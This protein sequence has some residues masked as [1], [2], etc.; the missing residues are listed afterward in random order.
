[1][2]SSSQPARREG[3]NYSESS[4][5]TGNLLVPSSRTVIGHKFMKTGQPVIIHIIRLGMNVG[6]KSSQNTT[7]TFKIQKNCPLTIHQHLIFHNL[8]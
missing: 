7:K 5:M 1:M 3:N 8:T 6:T 4:V 2:F